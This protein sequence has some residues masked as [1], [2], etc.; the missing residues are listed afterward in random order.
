[1]FLARFF[2]SL[3][4]LLT[5][6][7]PVYPIS[8]D[9][10]FGTGGKVTLTFPDSTNS[11]RSNG[12]R[13][14][15]QSATRIVAGGVFANMG[16]D[17]Q[18]TGVALAGFNSS[19]VIDGTFG[20]GGITKDWNPVAFT[21]FSDAY[22]YPD[23]R[24]LRL[25]QF[26]P[27]FSQPSAKVI[28]STA[29]GVDDPTFNANVNSGPSFTNNV[30]LRAAILPSGKIMVLVFAQTGPES[31]HLFRL[32]ADGSRDTTFGNNGDK[33]LNFVRFPNLRN[34]FM[35]VLPSGKIVLAGN[36][37]TTQ[38]NQNYNEFF[39]ARLNPA[40]D[41]DALFGRQGVLRYQ[42]G[43]GL[44]GFIADLIVTADGKYL[45]VGAINNPDSDTFMAKF[46]TRGRPDATFGVRGIAISD[47][48]PG[49][50]DY[51]ASVAE[52]PAGKL[53]TG[54]QSSPVGGISNFFVG[55]YSS[56]GT[57][58]DSL[59][60]E[61]GAGH[62]SYASDVAIQ[63]DGKI[64]AIGTTDDPDTPSPSTGKWAIARFTDK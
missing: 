11:Y 53:I 19:G 47:V 29:S 51:L 42:Y 15:Y 23:G 22:M 12:T 3:L 8:L 56:G 41:L 37:G 64:L 9:T 62:F 2:L 1:M 50:S 16:P 63:P 40:G 35:Q 28:R 24:L 58:E 21:G 43:A 45:A 38:Q 36:L 44:T 48:T 57:L 14:F 33:L 25:S 54:G 60:I 10:T 7:L 32:N 31:Y 6:I 17:G 5:A 49:A 61:F 52:S 4:L 55:R 39:I 13:I 26:F 46:T 20:S 18:A 34:I 27:I 30:P 59:S